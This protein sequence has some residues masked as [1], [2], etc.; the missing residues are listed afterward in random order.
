NTLRKNL[1]VPVLHI[2]DE[3]A[4]MKISKDLIKLVHNIDEK[5]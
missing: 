3:M 2:T 4:L 1:E 5:S